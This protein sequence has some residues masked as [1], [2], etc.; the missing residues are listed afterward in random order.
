MRRFAI[1]ILCACAAAHAETPAGLA[2][3]RLYT[4]LATACEALDLKTW[5]HATRKVLEANRATIEKVELCN[6]RKYPVFTARFPY[7]IN[8]QT[9]NYF[10]PLYLKLLEA[11]GGW[12][13]SIVAPED[14]AIVHVSKQ[15]GGMKLDREAF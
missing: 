7:D 15:P 1:L 8:G 11:N 13:Y 6:A 14:G 12:A 10:H 9:D 3:S 5:T 2:Q 4:K